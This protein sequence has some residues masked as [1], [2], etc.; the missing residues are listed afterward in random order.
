[1]NQTVNLRT[2]ATISGTQTN[3][4]SR[5][6]MLRE[7]KDGESIQAQFNSK[8]TQ[9]KTSALNLTPELSRLA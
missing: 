3:T 5:Q 4:K 9:Q 6:N 7:T 1:L 8:T 2:K